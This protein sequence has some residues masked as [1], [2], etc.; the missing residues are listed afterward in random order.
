MLLGQLLYVSVNSRAD[1]SA[2][3][4]ILTRRRATNLKMFGRSSIV[5][6]GIWWKRV[7][8]FV[9]VVTVDEMVWLVS[10]MSI[11]QRIGKIGNPTAL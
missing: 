3:A 6:Y 1:I 2:A 9:A 8:G 7:T 4:S 11:D 5:L 10:L